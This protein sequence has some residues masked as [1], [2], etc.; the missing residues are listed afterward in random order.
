MDFCTETAPQK[1]LVFLAKINIFE[2]GRKKSTFGAY[3]VVLPAVPEWRASPELLYK[4]QMRSRGKW[5][6]FRGSLKQ[7]VYNQQMNVAVFVWFES[8]I[9]P[10]GAFGAYIRAR[11]A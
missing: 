1:P 11:T 3:I 6:D 4:H 2:D 5:D 8:F 10:R 7:H 9:F